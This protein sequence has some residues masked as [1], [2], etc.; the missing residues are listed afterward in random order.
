ME[1]E[2]LNF[3][4]LFDSNYSAKGLA[5]YYSLVENCPSF[6]LFVFAFDDKLVNALERM[7]LEHVTVVPLKDFED[8]ELLAVK[9]T[10]TP[11][12]YCWT[13]SGSTILYCLQHFNIASCTYLDADLYFFTDPSVLIDELGD[14]DVLITEHRYTSEYDQSKTSGKYCVQFM[15]FKNNANGLKILKWWRNACLEWCYNRIED[16]KFGDQ[17]YLDDWTTR[18]QG[19]HELQ[20]LGGGVAPWNMQQYEFKYENGQVMGVE[21]KT[22]I[23]FPIVFFHF[24]SLQCYNKGLLRE[25]LLVDL[26]YNLPISAKKVLYKRYIPMLRRCY[27]QMKRINKDIN[28]LAIKYLPNSLDASWYIICKRIIRTSLSLEKYFSHWIEY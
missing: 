15:T 11:G 24:H 21:L 13:C 23:K 28:G 27:C 1:K 10:R 22:G 4:T 16:G 20:H 8:E 18:F 14:N 9:P 3:C 7:K 6:H 17:K 25:F 2:K 5:M 26:G 12:E 19:V